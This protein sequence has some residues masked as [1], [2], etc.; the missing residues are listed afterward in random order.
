V[1]GKFLC[2][3]GERFYVQGVTYGTFAETKLGLFPRR[4]RV[5]E[6]FAAMAAVSIN[7]VRTYTVP[8]PVILDIAEE[9]GLKLLIGVWWDDPRYL[10]PTNRGAWKKMSIEARGAVKEA[11]ASYAGHPALLGFVLGNEIPQ[12]VVRWHGRRRIEALLRSLYETGKEEAPDALFSYA[13]YP[14]TQYLD[15]SFFDFDC[16]NVFLEDESAYRRYLAQLQVSVGDRPLI[17]T[18]MGLDSGAGEDLQAAS[19]DWQ[20][21]TATE[22]GLAGTCIFSWTDDWWV[23]DYKVEGWYFGVTREHREPKPALKVVQNHYQKKPLDY[24][25]EWPKV[26]VVVCA[27]QAE[28]TIGACLQSL[29]DLTYPDYE[30]IVVDDGSTD[31]TSEIA[32]KFL[33]RLLCAGRLGLSGARNLG[34]ED[35]KGEIVAYIDSDAH[36]DPDWLTYLILALEAPNAA[37]VGGPN[38]VPQDDPPT[39]QCVARAPGGPIHVLLDDERAEHVPG[40]N[41]AFWR[42]RLLEIGEFDPIFRA[43]GDDVDVCWKLLESGYEIRFHPSAVVW[44]CR[45]NSVRA[46]WRQQVG[47]GRAEALVERN[48][49]DKFNNRGQASWRGVVYGSTSILLGRARIYSGR[50]GEAPFQRLY[51]EQQFFNP[52]P[53]LYLIPTLCLLAL[54]NPYLLLLPGASLAALVAIYLRHGTKIADRQK[55][56]P[57]WRIGALIGLLHLVQPM[58]RAW[59]RLR[60]QN[61]PVL[62]GRQTSWPLRSAGRGLFLTEGVGEVGREAFL[63][64][65][66][67]QLQVV[68][69]RPRVLSAWDEA[70]ITC[71]SAL[72]WR[73]QMLSYEGWDVFYLRLVRKLRLARLTVPAL[74][75]VLLS[76]WYPAASV[77]A[78]VGLL[79]V[80]LLDRW[81]FGRRVHRA[82]V[83][84]S[85]T[86]SHDKRRKPARVPRIQLRQ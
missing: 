66:R 77:G 57:V 19:L 35:A 12:P 60:S 42:E 72:F 83:T 27:Y 7:T 38:P 44:H 65:L 54:L 24:R 74:G 11:A 15:T 18:E 75:V 17:L 84:D 2:F 4:E 70:D 85:K 6:D 33:V 46:F 64:G 80:L 20:L 73:V 41:M 31:A 36:A 13:N 34:L 48:H 23:G 76:T 43:A 14:T 28:E 21:R 39:S 5:E 16:F 53:I 78:L 69:L 61:L 68:R 86:G 51:S 32:C 52:L 81:L 82:L 10:D 30:V 40:C 71:D 67:S 9:T 58:A 1:D 55:L 62:E 63:E 47:Y 22:L 8:E 49:P 79:A 26:S 56:R 50:F 45:R 3:D 59:G 29:A 25:K 37:G